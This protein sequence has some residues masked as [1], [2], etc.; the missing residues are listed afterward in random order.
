[1]FYKKYFNDITDIDQKDIFSGYNYKILFDSSET[2]HYSK[3]FKKISRHSLLMRDEIFTINES[4]YTASV[5]IFDTYRVNTDFSSDFV[6][7]NSV[8]NK[9][10]F[11]VYT[12]YGL[13]QR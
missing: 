10:I 9:N 8:Q 6:K 7:L 2:H 3:Y 1:M 11:N 13:C 5:D 4:G 12:V